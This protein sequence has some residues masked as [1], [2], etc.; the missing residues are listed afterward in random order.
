MPL[1]FALAPLFTKTRA[2]RPRLAE[3]ARLIGAALRDL[4]ETPPAG[5]MSLMPARP[6]R[7][8]RFYMRGP[9]PKWR[10][11]YGPFGQ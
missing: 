9:G 1:T 7:P 4:L 10:E 3:I 5:T 8:E 6:Y 11:K 2:A